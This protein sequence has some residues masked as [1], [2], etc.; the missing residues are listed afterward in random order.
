VERKAQTP[1]RVQSAYTHKWT[2]ISRPPYFT[3]LALWPIGDS[4]DGGSYFVDN[5]TLW[6][7]HA[8]APAH[9]NHRPRGLRVLN[10]SERERFAERSVRDGW[11]RAQEGRF[12]FEHSSAKDR[13]VGR[14]VRGTTEQ[15]TIWQKRQ[16]GGHYL[17]VTELYREPNVDTAVLSYVAS[18]DDTSASQT[19]IEG[20]TRIDWDHRG[21][22]YLR[23]KADCTLR[24]RHPTLRRR[25]C[26]PTSTP[27]RPSASRRLTGTVDGKGCM[28]VALY[29]RIWVL[30]RIW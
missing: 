12:S 29:A 18:A 6:L 26:L 30:T 15:P 27:T 16:P 2:A 3:A 9:P 11:E 24:R 19:L 4:W 28:H 13:L 23:A 25:G 14:G 21:V 7:C 1:E 17:L 8:S 5:A 10:T 20:V 22:S